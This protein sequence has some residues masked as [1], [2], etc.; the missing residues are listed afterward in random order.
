MAAAKESDGL[1]A[2]VPVEK[3]N[4]IIEETRSIAWEGTVHDIGIGGVTVTVTGALYSILSYVYSYL[5]T[6]NITWF[7]TELATALGT[8]VEML[9][10]WMTPDVI[11]L[12]LLSTV[13]GATIEP[14]TVEIAVRSTSDPSVRAIRV[15]QVKKAVELMKIPGTKAYEAVKTLFENISDDAKDKASEVVAAIRSAAAD[16]ASDAASATASA[17]KTGV[18]YAREFIMGPPGVTRLRDNILALRR[19]IYIYTEA[20]KVAK[21]DS[22]AERKVRDNANYLLGQIVTM[23]DKSELKDEDIEEY[24]AQ[25]LPGVTGKATEVSAAASRSAR[26]LSRWLSRVSGEAVDTIS[27]VGK[28]VF[29]GKLAEY[30]KDAA[31]SPLTEAAEEVDSMIRTLDEMGISPPEE[32]PLADP[33]K[34]DKVTVSRP[35]KRG[36]EEGD[37]SSAKRG[38]GSTGRHTV[39]KHKKRH[40]KKKSARRRKTVANR[41]GKSAHNR[42]RTN[43]RTSKRSK[44]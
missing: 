7:I 15:E 3:L 26:A 24:L 34:G 11:I 38:K 21:G 36:R 5:T 32:G 22:E 37:P 44:K 9:L 19:A 35:G 17:M 31:K 18:A 42:R 2:I 20:S 12:L 4:K 13:L 1:Q 8:T 43:R 16:A 10:P 28:Y 39:R 33:R 27:R 40:V 30:A 14:I 29:H 6:A 23:M 25:G 41:R